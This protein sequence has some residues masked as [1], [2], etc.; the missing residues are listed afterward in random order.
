MQYINNFVNI[1][2]KDNILNLSTPR[3]DL[4]KC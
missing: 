1:N 2:S 3:A 4:D